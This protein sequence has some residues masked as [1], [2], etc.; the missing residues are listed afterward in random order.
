MTSAFRTYDVAIIGGGASGLAAAI[1]AARAG[2]SVCII[3]R[4][5]ACGL[6]ILATGNGRC[7]LSNTRLAPARYHHEAAA[8]AV[9]GHRGEDRIA[10][11]FQ[12]LGLFTC[13]IEERLYPV[14]KRAESVRDCLLAACKRQGIDQRCGAHLTHAVRTDSRW[15]LE[16]EEPDRP[17]RIEPADSSR[18]ALRRARKALA[19][20]DLVHRS[21]DASAVIIATGGR[22]ADVCALFGLPHNEEQP[23][24]CPI[25][26]A[27][28]TADGTALA[29]D[30][31]PLPSLDG[32]RLDGMLALKRNGAA[33]AYEDG[34]VLLRPYGISGIAAFNLSRRCRPKDRIE[35]DLFPDLTTDR[36]ARILHERQAHVGP[37]TGEASWFDGVLARPLARYIAQGLDGHADPLTRCAHLLHHLTFEVIGTCEHQQAQVHRGG[38]PMDSVDLADLSLH[39]ASGLYACGEALDQDADCGGYNLAWAWLSGICAGEHAGAVSRPSY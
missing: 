36:L 32:L 5:V 31:S 38:I 33:I 19:E 23:L 21:V 39:D 20:S 9:L 8:R 7:N 18:P 1:A 12:Q 3:E 13:E 26:A 14:T 16:I 27:L 29:G 22:S 2:A 11:F 34:E 15:H 17:R 35:L 37:W 10:D 6:P 30:A 28:T 4:D 25:E 24:L